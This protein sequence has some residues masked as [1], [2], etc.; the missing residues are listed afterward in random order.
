MIGS[1]GA[2]SSNGLNLDVSGEELVHDTPWVIFRDL[3]SL[4]LE[5]PNL[6]LFQSVK[7]LGSAR[8]RVVAISIVCAVQPFRRR[9]PNLVAREP[10]KNM[11]AIV[12]ENPPG[13][14]CPV[15]TFRPLQSRGTEENEQEPGASPSA[16]IS[17]R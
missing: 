15:M 11:L 1:L 8:R 6:S 17:K 9:R 4:R 2:R 12:W 3:D 10:E 14:P 7:G 16:W 13:L 5:G